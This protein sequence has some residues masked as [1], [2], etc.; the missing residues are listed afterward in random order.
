[1]NHDF[2]Q[3][4]F[5]NAYEFRST[6]AIP[7]LFEAHCTFRYLHAKDGCIPRKYEVNTTI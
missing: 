1:M 2:L 5:K 7:V 3:R 6:R 4:V